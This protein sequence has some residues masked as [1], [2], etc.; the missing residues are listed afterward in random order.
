MTWATCGLTP[1]ARALPLALCSF[2]LVCGELAYGVSGGSGKSVLFLEGVLQG[3][4]AVV[5]T[6][7]CKAPCVGKDLGRTSPVPWNEF[8]IC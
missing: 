6:L 7:R 3:T 2:L 4:D 8:A 1:A 5:S